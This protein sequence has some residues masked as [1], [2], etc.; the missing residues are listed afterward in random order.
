V[1]GEQRIAKAFGLTG[2]NWAR[3][4]NPISVATRFAVHPQLGLEGRL[5][6]TSLVGAPPRAGT[7]QFTAGVLKVTYGIQAVGAVALIYGLV[8]LDLVATITGL[9]IPQTAKA[10]F[11]DA[12][13]CCSRR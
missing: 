6:R 5:R 13:C 1:T 11:I 8:R 9:V 2:D 4:A 7:A 3:H 12:R 10:W